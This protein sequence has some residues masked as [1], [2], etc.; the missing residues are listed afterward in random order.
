M[1]C[2]LGKV[3]GLSELERKCQDT[4]REIQ[5]LS[6]RQ[7]IFRKTIQGKLRVQSRARERLQDQNIEELKK[8]NTKKEEAL[9]LV[10]KENDLW[11]YQNEKD[12]KAPGN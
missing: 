9:E 5:M 11:R 1:Y 12:C 7:E 4:S 3:G 2:Q 8:W 10:R 6:K